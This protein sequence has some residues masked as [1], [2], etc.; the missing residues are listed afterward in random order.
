[1]EVRARADGLGVSWLESPLAASGTRDLW[2]ESRRRRMGN[3]SDL[4]GR[5]PSQPST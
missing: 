3:G 5:A 2:V 1:M 4:W